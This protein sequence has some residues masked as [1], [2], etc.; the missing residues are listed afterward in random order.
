MT[1]AIETLR[2]LRKKLKRVGG[3]CSSWK[4]KQQ[5]KQYEIKKL[6]SHLSSMRINRDKFK[7]QY[8]H[9]KEEVDELQQEAVKLKAE[10]N[11]QKKKLIVTD[12][13]KKKPK[14]SANRFCRES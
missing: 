6:K 3:S 12:F 5:N 2:D 9:L 14:Y 4:K 13:V 8:M 1:A 10:A 7:F 11:R